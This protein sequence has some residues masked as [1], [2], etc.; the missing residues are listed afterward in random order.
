[1]MNT[2]RTLL[3]VVVALMSAD[4][5]AMDGMD[6]RSG[7]LAPIPSLSNGAE[8]DLKPSSSNEFT[9]SQTTQAQLDEII[10]SAKKERAAAENVYRSGNLVLDGYKPEVSGDGKVKFSANIFNS[11]YAAAA[12]VVY[13]PDGKSVV[14]VKKVP[15]NGPSTSITGFVKDDMFIKNYK[16]L[17][18]VYGIGDVR[19]AGLSTKT[20]LANIEIPPGGRLEISKT[21]AF[22]SFF[23]LLDVVSNGAD[24][25][26]LDVSGSL[27]SKRLD[28]I[29][30]AV[31][32]AGLLEIIK[33]PSWFE[34]PQ[35]DVSAVVNKVV[36]IVAEVSLNPEAF[37]SSGVFQKVFK[38]AGKA[39][40]KVAV[41]AQIAAVTLNGIGRSCDLSRAWE[42]GDKYKFT[43]SY[44]DVVSDYRAI[45]GGNQA[46]AGLDVDTKILSSLITCVTSCGNSPLGTAGNNFNLGYTTP[47]QHLADIQSTVA[48]TQ[49]IRDSFLQDLQE[50]NLQTGMEQSIHVNTT[51]FASTDWKIVDVHGDPAIHLNTGISSFGSVTAP[52]SGPMAALNNAGADFTVMERRFTIPNGV[53]NISLGLNANFITNEF[54]TFLGSQYNDKVTIV[55]TTAS[56]N[57]YEGRIAGGQPVFDADLNNTSG[58]R[59][60][61]PVTG[62]PAPM[63]QTGGQTGFVAVQ[64]MTGIPV[65]NG[66]EVSVIVRVDNVGD[67]K[68]PSAV[69]INDTQV[70]PR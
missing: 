5:V 31:A 15:G 21:N 32:K 4:V 28:I 17:T 46:D 42:N 11:G 20:E 36:D 67:Q 12:L 58:R 19:D 50:K 49:A 8:F 64:G 69:L 43:A 23:N 66:G 14:S 1:M 68:F 53:R 9:L 3:A 27:D 44:S 61:T 62:L 65:A 55:L 16:S 39:Y 35:V 26:P 48:S 22:A 60:L 33:D 54:P 37:R 25:L 34:D 30:A 41:P 38:A 63:Q 24:L 51:P 57:T 45:V 13:G 18:D 29:V 10:L 56:G 7:T 70:A 52:N 40:E 59:N 47:S 2:N 6:P